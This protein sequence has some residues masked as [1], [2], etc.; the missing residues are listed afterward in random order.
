MI[1]AARA[2]RR[3]SAAPPQRRRWAFRTADPDP[4]SAPQSIVNVTDVEGLAILNAEILWLEAN[5]IYHRR[6]TDEAGLAVLPWARS[7]RWPR[8]QFS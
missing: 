8:G 3:S 2:T 7:G 5:G 1:H 4:N 6:T